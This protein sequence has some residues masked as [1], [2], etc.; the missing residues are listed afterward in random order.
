MLGFYGLDLIFHLITLI[1]KKNSD[2]SAKLMNISEIK[3]MLIY[4]VEHEIILRR[5][6]FYPMLIW[7]PI[8]ST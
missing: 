3:I 1:F 4:V 5:L 8:S 7:S 6:R 2:Y